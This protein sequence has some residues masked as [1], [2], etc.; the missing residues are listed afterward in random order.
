MSGREWALLTHLSGVVLLFSGLA[1]AAAALEGARKRERA[2]EVAALLGLT[3]TGVVLVAAGVLVVLFSGLW[4]IEVTDG[5]YSLSDGWIL[6]TLALL[7]ASVVLGAVGGRRPK[8][9][10][11]A[12]E[13]LDRDGA[14]ALGADVRALLDDGVSRAVNYAAGLCIV[15][16]LVLMVWKP[17]LT[18]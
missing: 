11:L 8:R 16:G 6:A 1:V 13:R 4:L 2:A 14:T 12:A 7:A 18:R 15:A 3:R 5:A 10:R 9:A 17:E